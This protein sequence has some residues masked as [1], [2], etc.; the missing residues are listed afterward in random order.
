MSDL[1]ERIAKA[2]HEKGAWCGLCSF[3]GEWDD[4]ADCRKT[5]L[6]YADAVLATLDL[7]VVP[8]LAIS[9]T[10]EV[11]DGVPFTIHRKVGDPFCGDESICAQ[12]EPVYR[13]GGSH[14]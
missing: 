3:E 12:H 11:I 1:R 5:L 14:E 9:R 6:D 4:C 7:Q 2:L 13:L 10:D 8:T